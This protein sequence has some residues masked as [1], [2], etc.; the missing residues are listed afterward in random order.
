MKKFRLLTLLTLVLYTSLSFG[1]KL[2]TPGGNI[3]TSSNNNV[4]IEFSRPEAKLDILGQT[5]GG[6][7]EPVLRLIDNRCFETDPEVISANI[8]EIT[9]KR[10]IEPGCQYKKLVVVDEVGKTGIGIENPKHQLSVEG[11]IFMTGEYSSL[12]FGDDL[13]LVN[14]QWGLEYADNGLN[15][16]KPY[17]SSDGIGGESNTRNHLLF[18]HDNG[19]IGI[20]T[21]AVTHDFKLS[22]AGKIRAH[23]VQVYVN[24]WADFV[25]EEDYSVMTIKNVEEF[26]E[27]N[28]HLPGVPSAE[29]VKESGINM[30]EMDAT[31]LMKIEELT[32]YI[33]DLQ[34]QINALK[35]QE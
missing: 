26:I 9:R 22:V 5:Y 27:K 29:E 10:F 35:K 33:I 11:N 34:K 25:F 16:W 2:F 31:L 1:Q 7:G 8:F 20:G 6:S 32:L 15:F 18:L 17:G 14:G 24:G 21:N 13:S 19:N 30:A 23:E 12:L 28:K 3:G 4:G